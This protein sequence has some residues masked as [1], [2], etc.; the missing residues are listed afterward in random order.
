VPGEYRLEVRVS[1]GR[2]TSTDR[3]VIDVRPKPVAEAG[4]DRM[5]AIGTRVT[6]D[7]SGSMAPGGH[8][9][10]FA[11]SLVSQPSGSQ[12]NLT[13]AEGPSV[14]FTPGAEG[15]YIVE[16]TVDNKAATASDRVT[17]TV[18]ASARRLG[19]TVYVSPDGDDAAKGTESAPVES[20]ERGLEI[21]RNDSEVDTVEVEA[22]QYQLDETASVEQELRVVGPEQSGASAEIEGADVLF[23]LRG[24]AYLTALDV[25]LESQKTAI[26]VGGEAGV[27]LLGATCRAWQCVATGSILGESGGRVE[28]RRT[29]IVSSGGE[30]TA[31]ISVANHRELVVVDSTIRGYPGAG[32][33]S[34]GGPTTI[35]GCTVKN[36]TNGVSVSFVTAPT[37]TSISSTDFRDNRKAVELFS[38]DGVTLSDA[39]SRFATR[40]F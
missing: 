8:D 3:V 38:A 16:L 12:A 35:R 13:G 10:S 30:Q 32:I 34:S 33:L 11:W 28:V 22:G 21:A 27:S 20:F 24:E 18:R 14:A 9:L 6:L 5:T 19:S 36:N 7:G 39:T 17:V 2:L 37:A 15:T 31:G 26:E 40:S 25:T 29:D 1:D 23:D 4:A